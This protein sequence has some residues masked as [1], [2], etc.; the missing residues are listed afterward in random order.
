MKSERN[1]NIEMLRGMAILMMLFYHYIQSIPGLLSPSLDATVFN[2][3]IGAISLALFY[4]ISGYGTYL[5]FERKENFR[6][7]DFVKRRCYGI[8]PH[9]YLVLFVT[10]LF[11]KP[12]I[13]GKYSIKD[14][15]MEFLFIHNYNPEGAT[16]NGVTWTIAL[17]MQFY[18]VAPLMYRFIKKY[19][20]VAT[21][22]FVLISLVIARF[23]CAWITRNE[24]SGIWL[25]A[26]SMRWLPT[27]LGVFALGMFAA[28]CKKRINCPNE[29]KFIV[30]ITLLLF[31]VV[32][33]YKLIYLVGGTYGDGYRFLIREPLMAACAALCIWLTG[34]L[35]F[36]YESVFGKVIQSVA[37]N[38]YGIYLW[39]M[40]LFGSVSQMSLYITY[41]EEHPLVLFVVIYLLAI[42]VG[43][44]FTKLVDSLE[45]RKIYT[46]LLKIKSDK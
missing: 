46:H 29:M 1:K 21:I 23:S 35:D 17:M 6:Y 44:V 3:A 43:I 31:M 38:Q 15:C 14:I 2:E 30:L 40:I 32:G 8:I 20:Y 27:N 10:I 5:L 42:F 41:K 7:M 45:Y 9:Y 28:R 37:R 16:I 25:V 12:Y 34:Q 4:T 26:A 33:F 36:T 13:I 19:P 39:H 22:I 24:M 18:L 11:I